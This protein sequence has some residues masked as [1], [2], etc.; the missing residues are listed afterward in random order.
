MTADLR[1]YMRRQRSSMPKLS[2]SIAYMSKLEV[3]SKSIA[4][5]WR[6]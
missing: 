6:R 1:P 4:G 2:G 5:G 3:L